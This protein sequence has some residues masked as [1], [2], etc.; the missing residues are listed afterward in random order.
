MSEPSQ[1]TAALP[2]RVRLGYGAAELSNSLTWT[3]FYVLFLFFLTDIVHMDPAF[4]GFIMMIGTV[5]DAV[6][7]PAMGVWSDTIKTRWGRRRPFILAAAL[8]FGLATWLLFT[9]FGLSE[10]WSKAYFIA[11]VILY[12]TAFDMLDIP[13][14]A[15][16]AEMTQ[17]YDERS[18]LIISRAVFC[19]IASILGA[20]LPL[21]AAEK[22][23]MLL[24]DRRLGWSVMTGLLGVFTI[25]PILWTWRATRRPRSAGCRGA[26][27]GGCS[28]PARWRRSRTCSCSTSR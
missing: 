22:L 5:Y 25:F 20:A 6:T 26:S 27:A 16:S 8:P 23:T 28:W 7:D 19:Q 11:V 18:R 15:L 9:D 21:F 10:G 13:Y 4:A 17:D 12:F 3:M 2:F 14:T 1:I 24:G